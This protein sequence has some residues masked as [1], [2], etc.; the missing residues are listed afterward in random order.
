MLRI[1]ALSVDRLI[2]P[3][4]YR[5]PTPANCPGVFFGCCVELR[6]QNYDA[7]TNEIAI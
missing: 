4:V 3:F 6:L 2:A 5:I 7:R 1:C